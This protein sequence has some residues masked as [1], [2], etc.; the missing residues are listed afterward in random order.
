MNKAMAKTRII[1]VDDHPFITE[2]I[3]ISLMGTEDMEIV[4]DAA[5]S[6]ELFSLL[7]EPFPDIILLDITLPGRSGIETVR[8]LSEEYPSIRVIMISANADEESIVYSLGAGARGYLTKNTGPGELV[9]AIRAVMAGED[10][11]G[12]S[13]SRNI[14]TNYL[15]KAKAGAASVNGRDFHLS[16]REKAIVKLIAEGLTYKEIGDKLCISARTVETHRNNIMQK[17]ELR[18]IADLIKYSIR[19]GITSL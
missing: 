7:A 5:D 16:E 18:T 1:V 12:E 6:E 3:R 8:I 9:R 19:E 11:L 14:V 10:Y 13:I 4:A 2:G 15:R 17:L